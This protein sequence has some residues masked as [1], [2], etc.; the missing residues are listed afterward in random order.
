MWKPTHRLTATIGTPRTVHCWLVVLDAAGNAYTRRDI[1]KNLLPTFQRL[2]E[3]Q[4]LYHN[5]DARKSQ[6]ITSR[7]KPLSAESPFALPMARS[8]RKVS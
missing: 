6:I 1:E 4:W 8:M 5:L 3:D 7:L 2:A